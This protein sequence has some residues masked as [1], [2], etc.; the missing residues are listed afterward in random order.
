MVRFKTLSLFCSFH[1]AL[2][3]SIPSWFDSR[4]EFND[5][6]RCISSKFQFHHGSIQDVATRKVAYIRMKVSIPSWF[7]SRLPGTRWQKNEITG[8]QF[9][10]G[11]IQD[12][13]QSPDRLCMKQVSI[14]SWFDSRRSLSEYSYRYRRSFNSIMVRF[15]TRRSMN[16]LPGADPVSIPSWFDSRRNLTPGS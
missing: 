2:R 1:L 9:H 6:R 5:G 10:H 16:L 13:I 12:I 3:V 14:P 4:L 11:S 15:K 8:F 7:D